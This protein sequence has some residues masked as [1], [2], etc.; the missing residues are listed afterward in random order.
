[1]NACVLTQVLF[2]SFIPYS[3]ST[4][5]LQLDASRASDMLSDENLT[6]RGGRNGCGSFCHHHR[7]RLPS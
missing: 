4:K 2:L 5:D 7:A 1:M 6:N 3:V